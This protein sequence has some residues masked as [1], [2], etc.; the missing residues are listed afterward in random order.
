MPRPLPPERRDR[1][2]EGP[3]SERLVQQ[4]LDADHRLRVRSDAADGG[5]RERAVH[6]LDPRRSRALDSRP[7]SPI[8]PANGSRPGPAR[9]PSS[10][11]LM[12][13]SAAVGTSLACGARARPKRGGRPGL[14]GAPLANARARFRRSPLDRLP[15]S[16][17]CC[18]RPH[19]SSRCAS[20]RSRS[21]T[22]E[23][24][25]SLGRSLSRDRDG[26][27]RR[28]HRSTRTTHR[29]RRARR[30]RRVARAEYR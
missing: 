2:R 5:D 15:R 21:A 9:R 22:P 23:T 18:P 28:C 11:S 6:S 13:A 30:A 8:W 17:A 24:T 20:T 3:P 25:A 19:P 12:S 29:M 1:A 27:S 10:Q 4:R 16:R 14:D 7:A 26:D